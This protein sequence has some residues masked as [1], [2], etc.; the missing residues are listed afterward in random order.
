MTKTVIYDIETLPAVEF[1]DWQTTLVTSM[2]GFK[3][4]EIVTFTSGRQTGKSLYLEYVNAMNEYL[5]GMSEPIKELTSA[6]VDGKPWYT[7]ECNQDIAEWIRSQNRT[8][9]YE[10]MDNRHGFKRS[11]FDVSDKL[12]TM[13]KVG[14]SA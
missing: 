10:H 2:S 14:F 13:I 12:Y 6:L 5:K 1:K 9:W 3:P 11:T 7:I 4:G 8:N